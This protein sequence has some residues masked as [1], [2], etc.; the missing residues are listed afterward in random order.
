MLY[1]FFFYFLQFLILI[2]IYIS[3]EQN[4]EIFSFIYEHLSTL[5]DYDPSCSMDMNNLENVGSLDN[6]DFY[7][8][9]NVFNDVRLIL[10]I[11]EKNSDVSSERD[12]STIYTL[13][14]PN[15][16]GL[17][18][19]EDID[20]GNKCTL[21]NFVNESQG[22]I[23][24]NKVENLCFPFQQEHSTMH[25]RES[26]NTGLMDLLG[27][28]HE[29]SYN[30]QNIFSEVQSALQGIQ[31]EYL[32]L[33]F[34][35]QHSTIHTTNYP[36]IDLINMQNEE[37]QNLQT[38]QNVFCYSP[39]SSAYKNGGFL[40]LLLREENLTTKTNE[41]LPGTSVMHMEDVKH[42]ESIK[43]ES[44]FS[45]FSKNE[46]KSYSVYTDKHKLEKGIEDGENKEKTDEQ[47][48]KEISQYIEDFCKDLRNSDSTLYNSS[49]EEKSSKKKSMKRKHEEI[50]NMDD[51]DI[52]NFLC[53][54]SI[55]NN[56]N[57]EG[58]ENLLYF[59]LDIFHL[60][61]NE[62][63]IGIV[64][65]LEKMV[66]YLKNGN[67]I[68][69]LE[70]KLK[71]NIIP[72]KE[73]I[74]E[75]LQKIDK[76]DL[77]A[78]KTYY[79]G[80][81][82]NIKLKKKIYSYINSFQHT[83][84]YELNNTKEIHNK[85][86]IFLKFLNNLLSE[87]EFIRHA[88]FFKSIVMNDAILNKLFLNGRIQSFG[89]FKRFFKL[90]KIM[91]DII[92]YKEE[93]L[94]GR[95][96]SD[97]SSEI[98]LSQKKICKCNE[99]LCKI[100]KINFTELRNI[101]NILNLSH[102]NYNIIVQIIF[103]FFIKENMKN[104][105]YLGEYI[106]KHHEINYA[107][108]LK[109]F[110]LKEKNNISKYYEEAS[111]FLNLDLNDK[112]KESIIFNDL[113]KDE[114]KKKYLAFLHKTLMNLIGSAYL[115]KQLCRI[116]NIRKSLIEI[117]SSKIR[118]SILDKSKKD[119]SKNYH[120]DL[121]TKLESEKSKLEK[122]KLNIKNIHSFFYLKE[123]IINIYIE[124][125][126]LKQKI[127]EMKSIFNFISRLISENERRKYLNNKKSCKMKIILF[128]LYY[129]NQKLDEFFEN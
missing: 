40:D 77:E 122:I 35:Q 115:R 128:S 71:T 42:Q 48:L 38:L 60:E 96:I 19:Y 73:Y 64:S 106:N 55:E 61:S 117:S 30:S 13:E 97:C 59:L 41:E 34:Q 31:V 89:N 103:H 43:P 83:I 7:D 104:I 15:D 2:N 102:D 120:L 125:D 12:Y 82:K 112:I 109:E 72:L 37:S 92:K 63:P 45:C 74:T 36:N 46:E 76:F 127:L 87:V 18:H 118:K 81:P 29:N 32:D 107:N 75:E 66:D 26:S 69:N 98:N 67:I 88:N 10:N 80:L 1:Y 20:Y 52:E 49:N 39:Y 51:E 11:D 90:F 129:I 124:T 44:S 110:L 84:N 116:M 23:L 54:Y 28:K 68:K 47:I 57:Y 16:I 121:L 94:K 119:L 86:N 65:N 3:Q 85:I 95:F 56:D 8:T 14:E 100:I 99:I 21:E 93:S 113:T 17:M 33:P 6:G 123:I 62:I 53:I 78:M 91:D 126:N 79:T 58:Y 9:R 108:F 27:E 22:T 50:D 70:K 111:K 101:L 4:N 5:S 105:K 25:T 24:D 114:K